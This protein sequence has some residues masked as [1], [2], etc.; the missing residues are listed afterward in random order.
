[1]LQSYSSQKPTM[2]VRN[3]ALSELDRLSDVGP[4][5]CVAI[6]VGDEEER[7]SRKESLPTKPVFYMR[8]L[9]RVRCYS[10]LNHPS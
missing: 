2:T 10:T 6:V 3:I 5:L 9:R 1:M 4:L 8:S 7:R